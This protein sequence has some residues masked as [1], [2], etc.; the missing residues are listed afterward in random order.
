MVKVLTKENLY[1]THGH[2]V[3]PVLGGEIDVGRGDSGAGW[4][5]GKGEKVGT[6]ATT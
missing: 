6:T 4:R 2:N 5:W 1:T 3:G